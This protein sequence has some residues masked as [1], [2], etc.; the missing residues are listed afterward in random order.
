MYAYFLSPWNNAPDQLAWE[1]LIRNGSLSYLNLI[2]YPHEGGTVLI[3]F[4]AKFFSYFTSFHSLSVT[5]FFIDFCSRLLQL[6]II[7]KHF[8]QKTFYW[9]SIW[10]LIS[11]PIIIPWSSVNFGLHALS[12]F[13]PFILIHLIK[14]YKPSTRYYLIS[15]LFTGFAIWFYY[16]NFILSIVF[17]AYLLMIKKDLKAFF[18]SSFIA[19]LILA[20]HFLIRQNF[21]AGFELLSYDLGNIRGTKF[22]FSTI[23]TFKHI[24]EVYPHAM[25]DLLIAGIKDSSA[26][27]AISFV[28]SGLVL[29]CFFKLFQ[30]IIQ[31]KYNCIKFSFLI[32]PIF[33]IIYAVSPFYFDSERTASYVN[34]RHL[35]Y[36]APFIFLLIINT[37]NQIKF[38]KFLNFVL[39]LICAIS[40]F[41]LFS[42]SKN[43]VASS[44][45]IGWVLANK[46][47]HKP[48][49]LSAIIEKSNYNKGEL[50]IGIGWG[51]SSAIIGGLDKPNS[52]EDNGEVKKLARLI[53]QFP[54]EYKS[55]LKEG[56]I[57]S[58]TDGYTPKLSE[59]YLEQTIININ[60]P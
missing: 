58:Y 35:T 9:F 17:L 23:E 26:I 10:Q 52:I 57:L 43:T 12:G 6:C 19:S 27:F 37:L 11:I 46:I 55:K 20:I 13:F 30:L 36:I 41:P 56:V 59:V 54:K 38:G 42:E 25:F 51:L 21:D 22:D 33:L 49:E 31:K 53:N 15:G 18:T 48:A 44:R 45:V 4:I 39:I 32:I 8:S 1:L 2:H 60:R 47:G 29:I 5:A 14:T 34:Y 7:K 24:Y 3:G 16:T 40:I 50:Y 28:W